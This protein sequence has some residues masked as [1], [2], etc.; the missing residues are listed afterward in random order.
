MTPSQQQP[1]RYRR[2]QVTVALTIPASPLLLEEAQARGWRLVYLWHWNNVL[3]ERIKPQGILTDELPDA[4]L[5]RDFQKKG[6]VCVRVG[7]LPH[8]GDDRLL[9]VLSDLEAEGRLAAEH[10]AE[11]D[12]EHVAFW[13]HQPWGDNKMQFKGFKQRAEALGMNC[14]L[15]R[16]APSISH[17]SSEEKTRQKRREFAEWLARLPKPIGLFA[18]GDWQ[19]ARQ[20]VDIDEAGLRVPDDVAVLSRGNDP[21]MCQSCIPSIS[22]LDLDEEGLLYAACDWLQR[23]M[24]GEPIPAKPIM[25]PPKG[26]IVRESTDILATPDRIVAVAMR[27]MWDHLNL[28]VSVVQIAGVVGLSASQLQRRFRQALG[29]SVIQELLRKRLEEAKHLL[30]STDLPIVDIAPKLGFHSATYMHRAFRRSFGLTPAQYR[31]KH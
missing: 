29:R 20:C 15:H 24:D 22:S 10:F 17:T 25:I 14:H 31:R 27:Y 6:C 28:D 23:L 12:F 11:R 8:P 16:Y 7:N 1:K 5:V 3:P 19:A 21:T 9:A 4:K 26:V 30:R 13:G 18:S 2:E